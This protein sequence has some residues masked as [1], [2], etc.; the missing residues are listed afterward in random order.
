MATSPKFTIKIALLYMT[1]LTVNACSASSQTNNVSSISNQCPDKPQEKEKLAL[2]NVKLISLDRQKVKESGMINPGKNLGYAFEAKSGQKLSYQTKDDIC[3]WVYTPDN[4]LLNSSVLPQTGKYTI[5]LASRQ[6][7]KTFELEMSL[8]A[9][10]EASSSPSQQANNSIIPE[11]AQNRPAADEFVKNHY[12][13]LKNRNYSS[14]WSELSPR[15][16]SLSVGSYSDYLQW[17][18]KVRDIRIGNVSLINQSNDTAIV[19]ADLYY[20]IDADRVFEDSKKRI[21]LVW[22]GEK[23]SWLIERKFVP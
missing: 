20:V 2:N 8:D 23:N 17:W 10:L 1:L 22:S 11:P 16:Q 12:F 3:I 19:D 5:Q 6:A 13:S 9:V 21:Y 4:Q 15:F 14:T 7:T 18:D